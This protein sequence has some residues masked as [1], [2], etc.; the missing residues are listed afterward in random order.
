MTSSQILA[1][2]PKKSRYFYPFSQKS[3]LI[4]LITTTAFQKIHVENTENTTLQICIGQVLK[5][6]EVASFEK[7]WEN[8]V[9]AFFDTV[10]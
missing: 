8:C 3:G 9:S 2:V 10:C 7:R 1:A 6:L 5:E 4:H